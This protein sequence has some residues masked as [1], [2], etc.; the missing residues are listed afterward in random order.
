MF[1]KQASFL[2]VFCIGLF[3]VPT[4][5][6]GSVVDDDGA[7]PTKK[8]RVCVEQSGVDG[9]FDEDTDSED[10]CWKRM[11]FDHLKACSGKGVG[12]NWWDIYIILPE[13]TQG[14]DGVLEAMMDIVFKTKENIVYAEKKYWWLAEPLRRP[15]PSLP[16]EHMMMNILVHSSPYANRNMTPA[17]L[18]HWFFTQGYD[19]KDMEDF[20]QLYKAVCLLC[21]VRL[22]TDLKS[23]ADFLGYVR[24]TPDLQSKNIDDLADIYERS[25][26]G[27]LSKKDKM[28]AGYI[29][30]LEKRAPKIVALMQR[31]ARDIV[32][33]CIS[34]REMSKEPGY[35]SPVEP[36]CSYDLTVPSLLGSKKASLLCC[37]TGA[38]NIGDVMRSSASL[39]GEDHSLQ[40]MG[41]SLSEEPS[42]ELEDL[43]DGT[44]QDI[45]ES[46]ADAFVCE[47]E[48][49]QGQ[50]SRETVMNKGK[51]CSE[52]NILLRQ[53]KKGYK[54]LLQAE[55]V[56]MM[57]IVFEHDLHITF[58][59]RSGEYWLV[60][61]KRDVTL[62]KD[63]EDVNVVVA[64]MACEKKNKGLGEVAFAVYQKGYKINAMHNLKIMWLAVR[65]LCEVDTSDASARI[66]EAVAFGHGLKTL[67]EIRESMKLYCVA[68]KCVLWNNWRNVV[69]HILLMDP[70]IKEQLKSFRLRRLGH[71]CDKNL[72]ELNVKKDF[73]EKLLEWVDQKVFLSHKNLLHFLPKKSTKVVDTL[74]YVFSAVLQKGVHV[75]YDGSTFSFYSRPE[76][77][78][79]V[80]IPMDV[81]IAG[82]FDGSVCDET[83]RVLFANKIYQAGY[84]ITSLE[85][86]FDRFDA[87]CIDR[88]IAVVGESRLVR[89]G[90]FWRYIKGSC[91]KKS[92]EE[93][94]EAYA[95]GAMITPDDMVLMRRLV[96]L[97]VRINFDAWELEPVCQ[98]DLSIGA[99]SGRRGR[100]VVRM[101]QEYTKRGMAC[102]YKTLDLILS[103]D[104]CKQRVLSTVMDLVFKANASIN[105]DEATGAYSAYNV[106]NKR[107]VG[108]LPITEFVLSQLKENP[109]IGCE[110]LAFSLHN[111]GYRLPSYQSAVDLHQV[112]WW[113][114]GGRCGARLLQQ[115]RPFLAFALEKM[116][117]EKK[118]CTIHLFGRLFQRSH[119]AL[120]PL[121]MNFSGSFLRLCDTYVLQKSFVDR[122]LGTKF[123][124]SV[125]TRTT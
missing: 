54:P 7:P 120:A 109:A 82:H 24:Y 42:S 44:G 28:L 118:K 32:C 5:V 26:E 80:C 89:C 68:N 110:E 46:T 53:L 6:F 25:G 55:L 85:D 50:A 91:E 2:Y 106:C 125:S 101:L 52:K 105:Y 74:K 70:A 13:E 41:D 61:G 16:P 71:W 33:G 83:T 51:G 14:E 92:L 77:L 37:D 59:A 112:F 1:L 12:S 62:P 45:V 111:S 49:G 27:Y 3:G 93:H 97:K 34:V 17:Q 39:P 81:M 87:V 57:T 60:E 122:V 35:A 96:D 64:R 23:L 9:G 90:G 22:N 8:M 63:A 36:G 86:F 121:H 29:F 98:G 102:S 15:K 117:L 67:K 56:R 76:V 94:R 103:C 58:E 40:L 104:G 95:Q 38:E 113:L 123:T 19:F 11:V 31:Y 20:L 119:P 116:L 75:N 69:E 48:E 18:A 66:R 21:N 73:I 4:C 108:V 78:P 84:K 100:F 114:N 65:I 107:S 124:A 79:E 10:C 88:N 43:L 115:C 99:L 47:S 30:A 72:V